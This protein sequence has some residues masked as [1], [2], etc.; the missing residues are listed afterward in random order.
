LGREDFIEVVE[1]EVCDL[2]MAEL[3]GG[4]ALQTFMKSFSL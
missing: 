1:D 2:N 4:A 3:G